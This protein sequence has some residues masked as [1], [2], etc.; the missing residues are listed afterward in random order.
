MTTLFLLLAV[1]SG[2]S[3][4]QNSDAS[5]GTFSSLLARVSAYLNQPAVRQ[6]STVAAV[7]AVRGGIPTDQG[8]NLDLRLLDRARQYRAALLRSDP[9]RGDARA[10][11]AIYEA[12]SASEDVQALAVVGATAGRED[13][14]KA[15]AA[16]AAAPRKPA[17]PADVSAL[18]SGPAERI[19]DK[20][21]V[22]AGWGGYVRGLTPT[23]AHPLG[24]KPGWSVGSD[25]A[26]LDESL[27]SVT[28]ALTH[29]V[30]ETN[31]QAQAHLLAAEIYRALAAA[32]LRGQADAAA[33]SS[34]AAL[35][36]DDEGPAP[37]A[38]DVPF[39]PK[40]IYQKASKSVVL[41]L[42]ASSEGSGELGTGS[43]VD[44]SR[45][46]ILTNAHV[47]IRD[48]TKEPWQQ[49]HVYFKPATMTGDPKRDLAN[50]VDGRVVAFD[51][52][53]DLAIVEVGSLPADAA[54]IPLDD[55]RGVAT[56]DRVAAIGHPEQGGLWTLT[57]GVVSTVVA[58]IGGVEGKNAFQ[59][60]TSINRGNS[61]G[62]LLDASGHIVGVNTSMARKAAD[63]LAITSVNF[64]IRSDVAHRWMA[65]QGEK[66]AYGGGAAQGTLVASNSAPS[67][68][69]DMAPPAPRA[70]PTHAA[71]RPTTAARPAPVTIPGEHYSRDALI[72]AEIAG[73][74]KLGDEMENEIHQKMNR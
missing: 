32:D 18:L 14:A 64:S 46:R 56:G 45:R 72:Q 35:P 66:I 36:A 69:P 16:W 3:F 6:R 5:S 61:G 28:D 59:T 57:T 74:E 54:A 31:E 58:N 25:A 71:P 47:V 48:A 33:A 22:A 39:D 2:P 60:D 43:V 27:K 21:L 73:M 38:V 30:L 65:A 10:L 26:R 9:S 52:A 40:T 42:C 17:L 50:P 23:D 67:A 34:T 70:R 53:L 55:P 63:G 68:A 37:A 7:A 51:R 20:A 41:I 12:L 62:P 11:R 24:S 4:A 1:L 19:E 13:A 15:L 44:A 49:I 8:E 29:K